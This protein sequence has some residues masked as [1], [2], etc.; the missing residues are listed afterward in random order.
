MN[1]DRPGAIVRTSERVDVPS[2][3]L[4]WAVTFVG[5]APRFCMMKVVSQ[6]ATFF[7]A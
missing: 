1:C 5:A 4:N 2:K 7:A 3:L 6:P